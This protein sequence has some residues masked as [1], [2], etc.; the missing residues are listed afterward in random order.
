[1]SYFWGGVVFLVLA[2]FLVMGT[3]LSPVLDMQERSGTRAQSL[4]EIDE[5]RNSIKGLR[6]ENLYQQNLIEDLKMKAGISQASAAGM[7]SLKK[8]FKENTVFSL[9]IIKLDQCL[10]TGDPYED[11]SPLFDMLSDETKGRPEIQFLMKLS[12]SGIPSKENLT[13]CLKET[14]TRE[15]DGHQTN[16]WQK[17]LNFFRSFSKEKEERSETSFKYLKHLIKED[18]I[19][20]AD[21]FAQKAYPTYTL[22][23]E[24]LNSRLK[25]QNAIK[26]LESLALNNLKEG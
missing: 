16:F 23:L 7:A 19:Q 12:L 3:Y 14:R 25:A 26:I 24:K 13:R 22:L 20:Q 18:K 1:M 15:E 17:I 10:R 9:L 21:V 4:S 6:E 5:L 2:G 8:Y 11:L